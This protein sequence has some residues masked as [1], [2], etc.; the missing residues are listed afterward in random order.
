METKFVQDD[1]FNFEEDNESLAKLNQT[2]QT[3]EKKKP[4]TYIEKGIN[5]QNYLSTN[6]KT[7][8]L[9]CVHLILLSIKEKLF[10]NFE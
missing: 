7:H 10:V 5:T 8:N 2:Y 1:D 3:K 9:D 6:N 4:R